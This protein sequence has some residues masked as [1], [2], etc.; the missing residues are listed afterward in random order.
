MEEQSLGYI[1]SATQKFETV[2]A[3][4]EWVFRGLFILVSLLQAMIRSSATGQ[5]CIEETELLK[6]EGQWLGWLILVQTVKILVMSI[7]HILL[8]R[9]KHGFFQD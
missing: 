4:M 1:T 9:K 8:N 3:V 2:Y 6:E 5:Y 7:W